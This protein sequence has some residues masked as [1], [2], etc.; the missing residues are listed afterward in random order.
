MAYIDDLF[1]LDGVRAVVTGGAGV[2]PGAMTEALVRSGAHVAVWGRG[3][4]H[5][6]GEAVKALGER[7]GKGDAIIGITV[8]TG[9]EEAVKRALAETEEK[10]GVPNLL[11]NGVGGNSGKGPFVDLDARVFEEIVSLNVMAGLVIPTKVFAR[12]W[13]ERKV[14][15]SIINIASMTSYIPL[16]GVW[17]YGAAKSAV[18]N[19]TM[20]TA[21]EFAPN[22]IRVNGIA[23]GFFIGNQ[24]RALL[25]K[26][27]ATGELTE[28]GASI[29]ARTPFG[30]FGEFSDLQG[31]TVFLASEAAS[32]FIT[33]VTIPIDGG[34]LVDN[35]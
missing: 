35:V 16:S 10:I 7:T 6:V 28:R 31:A 8:D 1:A 15:A 2:I 29:I 21:K 24:N 14:R 32:G 22:G 11:V 30:R 26:N 5:P 17:A 13:I 9:D 23:P 34:Y 4:G 12:Y 27:E 33:G 19:L 3:V 25:V 20:A 18:L